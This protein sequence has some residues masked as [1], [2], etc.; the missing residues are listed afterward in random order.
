V[1][2]DKPVADSRGY[3]T[4]CEKQ[5]SAH[6]PSG[7]LPRMRRI[8]RVAR[9]GYPGLRETGTVK[10]NG[11]TTGF[12]RDAGLGRRE[13]GAEASRAKAQKV[14]LASLR[15]VVRAPRKPRVTVRGHL[16]ACVR[17]MNGFTPAQT[18][19]SRV[20]HHPAGCVAPYARPRTGCHSLKGFEAL[21]S[22]G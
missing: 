13:A 11:Q 17:T 7:G 3:R 6:V 2:R 5:G 19:I 15:C 16:Y 10:R 22:Q 20:G 12:L 14:F 1:G 9:D 18:V 8:G 4:G 21:E